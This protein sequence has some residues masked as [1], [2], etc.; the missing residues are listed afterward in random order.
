MDTLQK[1]ARG[2]VEGVVRYLSA[3]KTGAHVPKVRSFLLRM[4]ASAKK[5]REAHVE[6]SIALTVI[7]KQEF[8]QFLTLL[9]NHPVQLHFS[10]NPG[11]IAGFLIRVGDWVVDTTLSGQIDDLAQSLL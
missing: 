6:S 2:F 8:R 4:T 9:T 10:V 11:H 5:Q 3:G 7:E 1:D